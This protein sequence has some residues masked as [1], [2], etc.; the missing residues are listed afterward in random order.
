MSEE[1][2]NVSRVQLE[3]I[4]ENIRQAQS[5]VIVTHER[6][7]ADALGSSLGLAHALR[8]VGKDVR[9]LSY[10]YIPENLRFLPGIETVV[11]G[12]PGPETDLVV[13]VDA[14]EAS[15]IGE[16]LYN[17]ILRHRIPLVVV[18]H[19]ESNTGYGAVSAIFP[20][21]AATA[22]VTLD[23]IQ[24][25]GIPLDPTIA[26][27]L[28]AG[29][30]FDTRGFSIP[31]TSPETMEAVALLMRHGGSLY[32]VMA[33]YRGQHRSAALRL[34]GEALRNLQVRDGIGWTAI[35]REMYQATGTRLEDT[36]GLA[37]F[38]LDASDVRIS[39]VFREKPEGGPIRVSGR[40]RPGINLVPLARAFRGGGHKMA[41]GFDV[42][43]PLE[44]AVQ[45]AL[46]RLEG[47][48]RAGR[49]EDPQTQ[50]PGGESPRP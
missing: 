42:D 13:A 46:E 9:V 33:A 44:E 10:E 30:V 1:A 28:M 31:D 18:D 3:R 2:Q 17:E 45:A 22:E 32:R 50:D 20:Q 16:R 25:L 41:V 27:C 6:P 21:R 48:R 14:G 36:E 49:L 37:N 19:H 15:Q 4:A 43:L 34:W 12:D 11:P 24:I 29:I 23:L 35:S 38:I 8:K 5:I 26:T 40:A 7:D 47:L 39:L